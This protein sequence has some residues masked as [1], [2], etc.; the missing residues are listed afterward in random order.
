MPGVTSAVLTGALVASGLAWS[1]GRRGPVAARLPV[2]LAAGLVHLHLVGSVAVL[3]ETFSVATLLLGLGIPWVLA[4]L[5]RSGG[6][7]DHVSPTLRPVWGDALVLIPLLAVGLFLDRHQPISEIDL[8]RTLP[9]ARSLVADGGAS[10]TAAPVT[11]GTHLV[12]AAGS[13]SGETGPDETVFWPLLLLGAIVLATRPR[14]SDSRPTDGAIAWWAALAFGLALVAVRRPFPVDDWIL[15]FA[16][17]ASVPLWTGREGREGDLDAGFLAATMAST[18]FVGGIAAVVS[19]V[20]R[21]AGVPGRPSRT[22]LLRVVG[23]PF[24]VVLG[25][26]LVGGGAFPSAAAFRL[27]DPRAWMAVVEG[28]T[29]SGVFLEWVGMPAVLL[30][31]PVVAWRRPECRGAVGAL[32]VPGLIGLWIATCKEG[33]PG[34]FVRD[35]AGRWLLLFVPAAWSLS[36]VGLAGAKGRDPVEAPAA[37]ETRERS[38]DSGR[39]VDAARQEWSEMLRAR[40]LIRLWTARGLTLRYK[41]SVLGVFWT[42]LEPLAVLSILIVVFSTVFRFDVPN[43]PIYL[44]PGWLA[45][46]FFAKSTLAISNETLEGVRLTTHLPVPRSA[47]AVSALLVHMVNWGIASV[48]MVLVLWVFGRP[49]EPVWLLVPLGMLLWSVFALGIG[50][51]VGTLNALFRDFGALFQ[52]ALTVWLYATPLIYPVEI[53]PERVRPLFLLNPLAH[54]VEL[55][56]APIYLGRPPSSAQWVASGCFALG[57]FWVGWHLFARARDEVTRR[58]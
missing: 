50:L 5:V 39:A 26:L 35:G 58:A 51:A 4:F 56:R 32:V 34:L 33:D 55:I 57:A 40:D 19:S 9:L 17:A 10:T 37:A 28:L 45:W 12:A 54:L 27:P 48:L 49:P 41:R 13:W 3:S 30:A 36:S 29:R 38:W 52:L 16:L 46:D 11:S 2:A 6:P 31:L 22:R 47:F 20:V 15:A 23:P 42:L 24:L 21:V 43:Y 44:L 14:S 8:G 1:H 25:W 53:L 7:G 18:G